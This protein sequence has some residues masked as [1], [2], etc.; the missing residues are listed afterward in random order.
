MSHVNKLRIERYVFVLSKEKYYFSMIQKFVIC[1]ALKFLMQNK[2]YKSERKKQSI[3]ISCKEDSKRISEEK[4]GN[5]RNTN[6]AEISCKMLKNT[7]VAI[8]N[9][10]PRFAT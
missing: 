4:A 6:D 5:K 9:Y 3:I 2:H 7:S 8:I 10:K 1:M